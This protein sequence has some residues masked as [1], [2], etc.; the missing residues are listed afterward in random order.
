[1]R[2]GSLSR[3]LS[4]GGSTGGAKDLGGV[5]AGVNALRSERRRFRGFILSSSESCTEGES[6]FCGNMFPNAGGV[7]DNGPSG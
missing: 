5:R 6:P 1:M 4:E 3:G 2:A 7:F